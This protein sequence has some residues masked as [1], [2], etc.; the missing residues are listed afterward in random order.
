MQ[1]FEKLGLF[2]LGRRYDVAAQ[3]P[4]D[5]LVLYDSRDLVTHAV[6]VGMTGSGK[7]GLCLCLLEEAAIDGIPALV[8]DPKG[9]LSNLLLTFPELRPEDFAPWINDDDAR[10]AGVEP[11]EY[12]RQQADL[13]RRG[14]AEWGQDG[15]RIKRMRAAA[16]VAIYTPGSTAGI[17]LSILQSFAPPG[18][19]VLDDPELLHEQIEAAARSLLGLLGLGSDAVGSREQTLLGNILENAWRAGRAIDLTALVREIQQPPFDRVGVIDL[20]SF[21]PA[22]ERFEL[23]LRLNNLIASPGFGVWLAGEPLD[24]GRLLYASDGKP[25]LAIVSI[26]HLNDEQRMFVVALLL[27][28]MLAWTRKQSGTTSLRAILYMDE[29][30]GYFPP[31]A[32]PPSKAPLLTL[33]KQGRAFGVGVVLATQNPVDLDYK[34]LSNAGTWFLGRLQTERDQQRVLDGLQTAAAGAPGFSRTELQPL[35]AGLKN[36]VFLLNNVHEQAPIV[37]QA[38]WALSYLRGPLGRDQIKRLMADRKP[39][40]Q[41]EPTNP[42]A[43]VAPARSTAAARPVLPPKISEYFLPARAPTGDAAIAY[44]PAIMAGVQIQFDDAKAQVSET[45]QLCAQRLV[46]E[47]AVAREWSW[48]DQSFDEADLDREP[49]PGATFTE[50]PAEATR[51][52][53]YTAWKKEVVDAAY[54]TRQITLYRASELDL[55]SKPGEERTAFV[56]RVRQ[57]AREARDAAVAELRRKHESKR[58]ALDDKVRRARQTVEREAD[59]ASRQ[60]RESWLT[61]GASI[62]AA[63]LSGRRAPASAMNRAERTFRQLGKAGKES[64]D[65]ERAKENLAGAE[66]DRSDLEARI[67]ADIAELGARYDAACDKIEEVAIRPRKTQIAVRW[68]GLVW[69]P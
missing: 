31:T 60:S 39:A 64:Q 33:M 59:Q 8:I 16:D 17:P 28:Q 30:A 46:G 41:P 37:F 36:R 67:Q 12:A 61:A 57:A 4:T 51:P 55:L 9:D 19:E 32:N 11:A 44:Q 62:L 1:D 26:A 29:I 38:R 7:T 34:G 53:S 27:W 52:P 18:A 22:K 68:I 66:D 5:E 65:V 20:E 24:V 42:A 47:G 49:A 40:D 43:T 48:L 50:L 56:A 23:S 14:L 21:F 10:R 45:R 6:C 13:W 3:E 63:V 15:E 58:A 54:Q 2:Y 25:R 35:L 69:L